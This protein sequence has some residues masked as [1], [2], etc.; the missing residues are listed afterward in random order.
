MSNTTASDQARRAFVEQLLATDGDGEGQLHAEYRTV[1]PIR[2]VL[3]AEGMPTR[4]VSIPVSVAPGM[5]MFDGLPGSGTPRIDVYISQEAGQ[6]WLTPLS[7]H[8]DSF[9]RPA[10]VIRRRPDATVPTEPLPALPVTADDLQPPRPLPP[11]PPP[12]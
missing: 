4:L 12:P 3:R 5:R 10:R 2:V 11:P 9:G 1:V 7:N 8:L 6:D